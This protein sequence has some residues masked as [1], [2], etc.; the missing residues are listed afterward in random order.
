MRWR[1]IETDGGDGCS[2][3]WTYLIPLLKMVK[4]V[5]FILH[6]FYHNKKFGGKIMIKEEPGTNK[7]HFQSLHSPI[8]TRHLTSEL[9]VV[10]EERAWG[11]QLPST[12]QL[13]TQA[14]W[15]P[16][17]HLKTALRSLS[18]AEFS[19]VQAS[20]CIIHLFLQQPKH[21]VRRSHRKSA[22]TLQIFLLGTNAAAPIAWGTGGTPWAR[23]PAP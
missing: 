15:L 13:I 2:K 3:L 10:R 7:S 22:F 19:S 11:Y 20:L 23:M 18:A 9:E 17:L 8:L 21:G 4:M 5:N 12:S 16:F 6:E 14:L 1:V